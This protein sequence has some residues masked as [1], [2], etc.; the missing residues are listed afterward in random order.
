[1]GY[2]QPEAT[3]H[4][5]IPAAQQYPDDAFNAAVLGRVGAVEQLANSMAS[6]ADA[7]RLRT[8]LQNQL[9]INATQYGSVQSQTGLAYLASQ[10][11]GVHT[12]YSGN[13]QTLVNS[14][15]NEPVLVPAATPGQL[16]N[17]AQNYTSEVAAAAHYTAQVPNFITS[18]PDAWTLLGDTLGACDENDGCD[19]CDFTIDQCGS[20]AAY[21]FFLYTDLVIDN[22]TGLFNAYTAEALI[23]SS[24]VQANESNSGLQVALTVNAP[25]LGSSSQ[26]GSDMYATASA[27]GQISQA[28]TYTA[29]GVAQPFFGCMVISGGAASSVSRRLLPTTWSRL[30][31]KRALSRRSIG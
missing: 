6:P 1:M 7:L 2:G 20:A 10:L 23:T 13:R 8:T 3:K 29:T 5:L 16:G 28:G 17:L 27:F 9:G 22:P 30:R 18:S 24:P 21:S 12:T 19:P 25:V 31:R 26:Q 4:I 15:H 14:L 11:Q